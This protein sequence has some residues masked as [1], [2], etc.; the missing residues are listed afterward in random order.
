MSP[1]LS[2][3]GATR[4]G[5]TSASASAPAPRSWPRASITT[6]WAPTRG[7]PPARAPRPSDRPGLDSFELRMR[8]V[9]AVDAAADGPR[10]GGRCGRARRRLGRLRRR[11]RKSGLAQLAVVAAGCSAAEPWLS[12]WWHAAHCVPRCR[13]S[14]GST[15]RADLGCVRTARVE[16]TSGWRGGRRRNIALE[17]PLFALGVR[18]RVWDRH[19]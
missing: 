10:E 5:S 9:D 14:S 16:A 8:T 13:T 19:R 12:G 4:S 11:R 6:T 2:S 7:N 3:S 17:D 15:V 18:A 1:A